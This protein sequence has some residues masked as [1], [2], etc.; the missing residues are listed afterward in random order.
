MSRAVAEMMPAVTEPP[1]PN[2]LPI[3]STQ[4]PTRAC[5]E[6]PQFAAGSGPFA[7]TFGKARSVPASRPMICACNVVSSENV[8]V[9]CSALA[10]TWL[11]VTMRPAGSIIKPEPSEAARGD[12][13]LPGAPFSPKKSRKKS[14]SGAPGVPGGSCEP[15]DPCGA[16]CAILACGCAICVETLTTTPTSRPA[17][18]EKTSAKGDSGTRAFALSARPLS[19]GSAAG[20]ALASCVFGGAA[21]AVPAGAVPGDAMPGGFS[22]G[23]GCAASAG[24]GGFLS[25]CGAPLPCGACVRAGS[26]GC[27][28]SGAA[29]TM[30]SASDAAHA[31]LRRPNSLTTDLLFAAL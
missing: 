27:A 31:A 30:Q 19:D 7:L 21:S 16:S 6:S 1:S 5:A 22:E 11:F 20:P 18:C 13:E 25:G 14:S 2:G 8:T 17:I 24:T 26:C 15:G 3:A 28:P 29:T 23:C 4:S 9:T 10:I 12:P